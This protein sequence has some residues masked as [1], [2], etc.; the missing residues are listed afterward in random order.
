MENMQYQQAQVFFNQVL[1]KF[2]SDA[3]ALKGVASARESLAR[4]EEKK[5]KDGLKKKFDGYLESATSKLAAGMYVEAIQWRPPEA[6][7]V[8]PQRCR[9]G[10]PGRGGAREQ[11]ARSWKWSR[12]MTCTQ[13]VAFTAS[14]NRPS[15][16]WATRITR[17]PSRRMASPTKLFPDD[18]PGQ[19]RAQQRAQMKGKQLQAELQAL[20]NQYAVL[21]NQ[22]KLT[23]PRRDSFP[24]R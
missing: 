4:A 7:L 11:A 1:E 3:V 20:Q 22:G 6:R 23:M 13:K 8:Q 9:P 19:D 10:C 5:T 18:V 16:P 15:S 14:W 24:M 2:P 17:K 12:T 21:M